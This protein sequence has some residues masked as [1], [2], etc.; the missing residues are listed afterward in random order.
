MSFSRFH[1]GSNK[2][3]TVSIMY[4]LISIQ[5]NGRLHMM[6]IVL[7]KRIRGTDRV[8]HSVVTEVAL[9]QG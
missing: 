9:V 1:L 2:A 5:G 3:R 6:I 8:E 4:L 7:M